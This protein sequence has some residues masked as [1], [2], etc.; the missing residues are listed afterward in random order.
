MSLLKNYWNASRRKSFKQKEEIIVQLQEQ[1]NIDKVRLSSS[2]TVADYRQLEKQQDRLKISYFV[3]ERFSERYICPLEKVPHAYKN[4]FSIMACCCLMIE[5]LESF[6]EGSED[7]KGNS[8]SCFDSF[9]QRALQFSIFKEVSSEFYINVRCK[10]LH[11]AETTGGWRILRKGE[12]FDRDNLTINASKFLK[13]LKEYLDGYVEELNSSDW[14]SDIWE[15][16]RKKMD[17]IIK[18]CE[19]DNSN[20]K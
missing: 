4:G 8:K 5:A 9:F 1:S 7:T 10:I 19:K 17:A 3:K 13:S 15:N 14:G 18:N 12:L 2:V 11:Q 20:G 16:L 6:Y